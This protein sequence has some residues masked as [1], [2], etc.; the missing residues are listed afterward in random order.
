MRETMTVLQE[1]YAMPSFIAL[2]EL[3]RGARTDSELMK[4]MAPLETGLDEKISES[5]VK[6]FP[7][8]ASIPETSEVLRDLMLNSLQ[9]IAM[10]PVPYLKGERLE[11]LLDLL[12]R[13]GMSEFERA[14]AE[15]DGGEAVSAAAESA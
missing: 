8:W 14:I 15:A 1:Y 11:R 9:G 13:V 3:L 5:I 10:D 4:V 7:V 6:R 2:Q 12:A